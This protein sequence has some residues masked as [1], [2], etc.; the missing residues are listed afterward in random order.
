MERKG[1]EGSRIGPK[2]RWSYDAVSVDSS[3]DPVG[4]SEDGI[5]IKSCLRLKR[6]S[7]NLIILH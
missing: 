7:W 1:Q 4:S 2:D 3:A 6:E 5:A